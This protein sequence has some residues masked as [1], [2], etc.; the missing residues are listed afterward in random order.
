MHANVFKPHTGTKTS[1]LLVQKWDETTPNPS[2]GGEL[3]LCPKVED[4]P[5]FFA[6]MQ[7]P[8]KDN[9]GEKIYIRKRD[10]PNVYKVEPIVPQPVQGELELKEP[11]IQYVKTVQNLDEYVLDTHGHLII[12][13]DLFNHDGLTRDGIAEAFAEFAKK[14]QLSF[15]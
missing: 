5:I 8:S 14:E 13:H 11:E 4:Y 10:L 7:E 12:K 6:S 15:F 1:V 2:K 3:G 9:S